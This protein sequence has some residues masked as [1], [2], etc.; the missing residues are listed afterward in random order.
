MAKIYF[1]KRNNETENILKGMFKKAV[2]ESEH[3]SEEK[4]KE[5]IKKWQC[6]LQK[7]EKLQLPSEKF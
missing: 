5:E 7:S 1:L 4:R 2:S 3:I 6:L